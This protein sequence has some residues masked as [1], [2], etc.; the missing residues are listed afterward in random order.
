[1]A[2]KILAA[3]L[4]LVLA[5]C[6]GG[7]DDP[8]DNRP[9]FTEAVTSADISSSATYPITHHYATAG[10]YTLTVTGQFTVGRYSVPDR[11]AVWYSYGGHGTV[12]GTSQ[13][14]YAVSASGQVINVSQELTL[15]T[16]GAGPWEMQ[17]LCFTDTSAGTMANLRL[18]SVLN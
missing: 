12:S 18:T 9:S 10:T 13:P 3:L 6:G 16:T 14:N 7:G 8:P 11:L 4:A 5:G 1:M 2:T 15:T 17:I